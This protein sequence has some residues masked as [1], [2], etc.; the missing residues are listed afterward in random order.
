MIHERYD[1]H[2]GAI[3]FKKDPESLKLEEVYQEVIKLRKEVK[4]LKRKV[5]VLSKEQ[6]TEETE[7]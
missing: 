2:S 4:L 7:E 1:R 6:D 5:K 3:L